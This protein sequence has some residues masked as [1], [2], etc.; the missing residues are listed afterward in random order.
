MRRGI[1][2]VFS[3]LFQRYV[4][5]GLAIAIVELESLEARLLTAPSE[6][7]RSPAWSSSGTGSNGSRE[8][9]RLAGADTRHHVSLADDFP[10]Y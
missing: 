10:Q 8:S 2:H 3:L 9:F 1:L 6:I 4:D 7:S 5:D